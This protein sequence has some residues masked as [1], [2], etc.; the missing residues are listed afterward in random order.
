MSRLFFAYVTE[1]NGCQRCLLTN[2]LWYIQ[3]VLV[4][5]IGI[6]LFYFLAQRYVYSQ[7]FFAEKIVAF[8]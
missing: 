5:F 7:T 3:N 4:L 6:I 1:V 2:I 8:V